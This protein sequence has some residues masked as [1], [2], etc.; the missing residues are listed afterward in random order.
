MH[1]SLHESCFQFIDDR[2]SSL[3]LLRACCSTRLR[4]KLYR[5]NPNIGCD[6]IMSMAVMQLHSIV[7]RYSDGLH[8]LVCQHVADQAEQRICEK[9]GF[10]YLI[11]LNRE[12]P[13]QD[14]W[15]GALCVV[16]DCKV[17]CKNNYIGDIKGFVGCSWLDIMA[18]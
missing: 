18:W 1:L 5:H 17:I 2:T 12:E 10:G 9:E 7:S 13:S 4:T 8:C 3:T 16:Q 11:Q 14:K 15:D 6:A